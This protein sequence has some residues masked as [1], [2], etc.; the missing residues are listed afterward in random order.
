MLGRTAKTWFWIL[1]AGLMAFSVVG[2]TRLRF[3]FSFEAFLPQDDADLDF[4]RLQQQHFGQGGP[5]VNVA[6]P[7][8]PKI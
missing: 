5:S 1:F 4:Y 7:H 3:D 6:L 8:H 2:V